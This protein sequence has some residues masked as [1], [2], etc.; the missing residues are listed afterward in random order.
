MDV[1][2]EG[3]IYIEGSFEQCC[4]G[5]K[6]GKISEIKKILKG[7]EHFDYGKKIILP[8]GIDIHVHFR[9]PG[10][11]NKEDFYTGTVAAAYGGIS[12]IFDMPNTNP[13]TT[14]LKA[15]DE[16]IKNCSG[17]AVV[18][19]GL[20][21]GLLDNNIDKIKSMADKCSGFKIYLGSTTN[22][23]LFNK[24][25]IKD[26]L[27]EISKTGKPVLFHAED[28]DCLRKNKSYERNLRDHLRF[29]PSDCEEKAIREIL[30]ASKDI[31]SKIHLCHVSSL[32][33]LKL[34]KEKPKNLTFAITPHH[35]LF[36]VEQE[37]SNPTFYKVN[38]PIRSSFD[39]EALFNSLKDGNA[40]V[41][42]SDHAP[43]TIDEKDVDFDS[44]P[45]GLP[46]V[47]TMYPIFLYFAKKEII[48]FQRLVS[49]ISTKPAEILN[50]RKG[51]IEVGYDADLIVVDIKKEFKIK[52]ENLH[53]KCGWT[54]YED[55]YAIFPETLFVRGE[56]VID[57]FEIQVDQGFGRFV[58]A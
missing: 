29:R 52:G 31:N 11:T 39:R 7:D 20:Y 1:S 15:L 56:K 44:A 30:D 38:P 53:S 25:Y 50:V 32:E 40:D 23:L 21:A 46:G 14:S 19:F 35:S 47:E 22:S 48:K 34:L 5:I 51:K 9:D 33:G 16:K 18:D 41:L 2:I 12:C 43:H 10:L 28:E 6:D 3:K 26:A 27:N 24:M 49:L 45:S 42:E 57:D 13:P 58:G 17:K 55:F 54:P 8:A 36:S 4:I 37:F